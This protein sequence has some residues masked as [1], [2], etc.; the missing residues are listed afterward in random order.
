MKE[1][2]SKNVR[3][4]PPAIIREM[5]L[6][7]AAYDNV[8][9]LG[10]GEPDFDTPEHICKAA[11][12][13]ALKG[14][15]H[16]T[17]SRGYDDL[18]LALIDHIE[19][20]R[21]IQLK[22]EQVMVT[23]GGMGALIASLRAVLDPG[24]EV[25]V[26][27]PHFPTYKA[28]IAFAGG[29][30]VYV[31]TS[32]QNRFIVDPVQIEKSI[33]PKTK[34]LIVNSPNNPTGAVMPGDLLDELAR[35]AVEN[36]LIVIS[37]EVYDRLVFEGN[38][39]SIYV[40]PGMQERTVVVN[41]FSKAFAMTGWRIG[42]CFGP[43]WIIAEAL[44]VATYFTSCPSS[45]GQRAAMAA[46]KSDQGI[47]EGM[48]QEFADRCKIAYERLVA[49]PGIKVHPTQGSFY[50]FPSVDELSRDT[51]KFALDLLDR[52]QVVV[53]PGEAFGPSGKGCIRISCTVGRSDLIE[54]MERL[55]R[56][57]RSYR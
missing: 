3:E 34:A 4:I 41:S 48:V 47:F 39:D 11:L 46:L 9:S 1:K 23:H 36:D 27:E 54:A 14:F 17:P 53:I 12:Q 51:M 57:V 31:S 43:E 32:F 56:F 15:T 45:I 13:D 30:H 40:R 25:I 49:M 8:I 29:T 5:S 55:E 37:D 38:H 52:E 16:Y 18:I 22:P 19:A 6:R 33:T 28:Q 26:I 21:N 10:I 50:L 42:Y 24:D 35:I 2:I 20:S 7:A 44:K